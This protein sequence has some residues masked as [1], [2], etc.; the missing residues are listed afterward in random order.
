VTTVA[1]TRLRA[2]AGAG[3]RTLGDWQAAGL[4]L[5]LAV[6]TRF[7]FLSADPPPDVQR[8]YFW[9]EGL[10]AH[11]ARVH[12]LLGTWV[13]DDHN[14]PLVL[15]PLYTFTLRAVYGVLGFGL[16]ET[17][18]LTALSGVLTCLLLYWAVRAVRPVREA[19][20][21]AL[22]FTL[23]YFVVTHQRIAYT[24][25]YQLLWVMLGVGGVLWG[26]RN[27]R[28]AAVGGVGLALA[29]LVKPSALIVLPAVILLWAWR[30]LEARREEGR[31][32]I[33]WAMIGWF[34]A[35]GLLVAV[36]VALAVLPRWAVIWK[37]LQVSLYN[38]GELSNTPR[39]ELVPGVYRLPHL[40]LALQGAVPVAVAGLLAWL[41]LAGHRDDRPD[42]VEVLAWGWLGIAIAGLGVLQYQPDRRFLILGP[43]LAMLF[44]TAVGRARI[45]A[46]RGEAGLLR[47]ALGGGLLGFALGWVAVAVGNQ[48]RPGVDEAKWQLVWWAAIGGAMLVAAAVHPA[49][50][51]AAARVGL[52]GAVPLFLL[53]EPLRCGVALLRRTDSMQ[54]AVDRLAALDRTLPDSAR[55]LLGHPGSTLSLGSR[56]LA[57]PTRESELPAGRMNE[58]VWERFHPALVVYTVSNRGRF[59]HG[60]EAAARGFQRCMQFELLPDR[61]GRPF[62][63]VELA[64][65][66][67]LMVGCDS[68]AAD[69][70][71]H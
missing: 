64:V 54:Q 30:A 16:V 20:G 25:A 52:S 32:R 23:S 39:V 68:A 71:G 46:G 66:P 59:V 9:D 40:G 61:S 19:L 38:A 18:L 50:L 44:V 7:L 11:N 55:V 22:V 60:D 2:E 13:V 63:R 10:W 43:P 45:M 41:R 3:R 35:G 26:L 31:V 62:R 14:P 36:P 24:E 53:A 70:A 27:P 5:A 42:G 48:L 69:R 1:E 21:V 4:I 56:I 65:R 57:I 8:H 29:Q 17:R 15:A 47:R 51:R 49:L 37:Y 34:A 6:L 28:W 33:P 58:D 12:A 67:D